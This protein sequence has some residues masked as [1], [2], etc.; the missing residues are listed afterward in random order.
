MTDSITAGLVQRI[1][2]VRPFHY[3]GRVTEVVGTLIEA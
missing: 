2:N 3:R 1:Q